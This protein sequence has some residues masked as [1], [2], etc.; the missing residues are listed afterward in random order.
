MGGWV[1]R[2]GRSLRWRAGM[3]LG[4]AVLAGTGVA[5]VLHPPLLIWVLAGLLCGLG[6]LLAL[7]GI[8]ARGR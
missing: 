7:S 1:D 5:L 8:C 6:L 2:G 3:L 4:G